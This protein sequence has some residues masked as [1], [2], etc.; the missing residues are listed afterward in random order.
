M[1]RLTSQEI[2]KV[3]DNLIGGTEAVGDS[4]ADEKIMFNLQTLIDVTNWCLD[5]VNQSS[6]TM[7]RPEGS[8]HN[9]GF[10]AN[11]ALDEWRVWLNELLE[12]R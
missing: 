3:L 11:C 7:G 5:G 8:M 4:W 1:S 6:G 12:E 9:I 10:T 2:I